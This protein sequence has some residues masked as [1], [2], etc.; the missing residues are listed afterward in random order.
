MK[1]TGN[2]KKTNKHDT[3]YC[4]EHLTDRDE[5]KKC[6]FMT[7]D[8]PVAD[9]CPMCGQTMFKKS[10]KGFKKPFCINEKCENFTPE[11]KR[12]GWKKK[13]AGDG[14]EAQEET[15][16]GKKPAKPAATKKPAA[17]KTAAAKKPAAKKTAAKKA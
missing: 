15:A 4:C 12:G 17:K 3:Y 16:E 7:W 14:G 8:V 13:P 9:D 10:G 6:D 1:H 2:I 11:E 5:S